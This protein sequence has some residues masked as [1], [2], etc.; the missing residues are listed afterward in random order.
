MPLFSG[1]SVRVR[2]IAYCVLSIFAIITIWCLVSYWKS[3]PERIYA[4]GKVIL[5]EEGPFA[6]RQYF[7]SKKFETSHDLVLFGLAWTYFVQ[8]DHKTAKSLSVRLSTDAKNRMVQAHAAYLNAFIS[9][10]DGE[11]TRALELFHKADTYYQKHGPKFPRKNTLLG[12]AYGYALSGDFENSKKFLFSAE[13]SNG[14]EGYS[15][16]LLYEIKILI[17]DHEN[18]FDEAYQQSVHFSRSIVRDDHI[19]ATVY[20]LSHLIYYGILSGRYEEVKERF[21]LASSISYTNE[22]S[23]IYWY[24]KLCTILYRKCNE[25]EDLGDDLLDILAW[26]E[27]Y[28]VQPLVPKINRVKTWT[29]L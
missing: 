9:I 16:A 18:D 15:D 1:P 27:E 12:L 10:D 14:S 28:R 22:K 5:E 7:V 23:T 19:K 11:Y 20:A 3:T 24:F 8:G 29:C 13:N 17:S 21:I 6:A 4:K 25:G 26:V 2:S